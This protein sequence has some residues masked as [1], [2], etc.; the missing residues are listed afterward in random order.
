MEVVP[1]GGWTVAAANHPR[2]KK[3]YITG[4]FVDKD[5]PRDPRHPPR[6]A[7]PPRPP[8]PPPPVDP[9]GSDRGVWDVVDV[10]EDA[11]GWPLD[12]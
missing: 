8:P 11:F 1:W 2:K 6:P 5:C 12:S 4:S 3:M 7:P 10:D 9:G